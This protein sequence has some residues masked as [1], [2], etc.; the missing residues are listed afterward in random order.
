M[1]TSQ[2]YYNISTKVENKIKFFHF[3]FL[4]YIEVSFHFYCTLL[5]LHIHEGI[6][7]LYI[8]ISKLN[9]IIPCLLYIYI[10]HGAKNIMMD[11]IIVLSKNAISR[12][13]LFLKHNQRIFSGAEQNNIKNKGKGSNYS[14]QETD[15]F[16]HTHIAKCN[17][18]LYV[19]REYRNYQLYKDL[20]QT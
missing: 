6:Q 4:F 8:K 20:S 17:F 2:L 7:K 1:Y 3:I 19:L 5:F 11:K 9:S 16:I 15:I 18:C 10:L 14:C 13:Y 12:F